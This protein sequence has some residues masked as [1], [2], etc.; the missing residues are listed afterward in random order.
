MNSWSYPSREANAAK[1]WWS[2]RD[3]PSGSRTLGIATRW[4]SENPAAKSSRSKLVATG[5]TMSANFAVVF[6]QAS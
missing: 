3:S 5:R 1:M 4:G 6:H 2:V